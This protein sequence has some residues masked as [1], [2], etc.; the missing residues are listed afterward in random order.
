MKPVIVE[1]SD[2][3]A[4]ALSI[5]REGTRGKARAAGGIRPEEFPRLTR[6]A[7]RSVSLPALPYSRLLQTKEKVDTL[8]LDCVLVATGRAPYTAGLN[9]PAVGAAADRR[10][11]IPTD[12]HMQ[13]ALGPDSSAFPAAVTLSLSPPKNAP[14]SSF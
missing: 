2:A 14:C 9:L 10:G 4:R 6:L 5:A 13:G 3:K 7:C 1:L 8:E 12:D 11:F